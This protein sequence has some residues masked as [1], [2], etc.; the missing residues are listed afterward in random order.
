MK[1]LALAIALAMATSTLAYAANQGLTFGGATL[2]DSV[3][4]ETD[5]TMLSYWGGWIAG[6]WS[7]LN[8]M[9][10]TSQQSWVGANLGN[11]KKDSGAIVQ[12]V[13]SDC[14]VHPHEALQEA[15][16]AAYNRTQAAGL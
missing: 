10:S 14:L 9:Q 8:S 11:N 3:T 5:P 12:A 2:C 13:W 7:G 1:S 4:Y 15:V 16:N 6:Y